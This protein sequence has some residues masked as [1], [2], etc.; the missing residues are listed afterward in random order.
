MESSEK[1]ETQNSTS[2]G[3]SWWGRGL[4]LQFP[5]K[6]HP[7]IVSPFGPAGDFDFK[8]QIRTLFENTIRFIDK[9]HMGDSPCSKPYKTC[10]TLIILEPE[11][12]NGLQ[13][14]QKALGLSLKVDDILRLREMSKN[15]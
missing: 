14:Y 5:N 10:R 15:R 1:P 2:G 4:R 9:T 11:T 3:Q 8:F 13:D 7:L 12:Q 6:K